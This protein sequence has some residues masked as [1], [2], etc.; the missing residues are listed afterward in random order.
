M[1]DYKALYFFLF[2][3]ISDIIKEI[4]K[5]EDFK[6]KAKFICYLKILQAG[7]EELYL[8]QGDEEDD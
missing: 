7:S 3:G 1:E 6:D 4:E 2:N 5:S 8:K